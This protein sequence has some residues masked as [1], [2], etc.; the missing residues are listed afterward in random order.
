MK[1]GLFL[2]LILLIANACTN[3]EQY[4]VSG[5]IEGAKDKMLYLERMDLNQTVII[6]SVKIKNGDFEFKQDRLTEPTF[7]MLKL[8][9]KNYITLLADTTETI[10]INADAKNLE[11]S[12]QLRN[13]IGSVYIQMF[14]KRIRKLNKELNTLVAKY[15]ATDNSEM[16][17]ELEKEYD[18]KLQEHKAFVGEFIMENPRSF[19]GYYAL[20]QNLDDNSAVLNVFDK[21]DQVYFSTLATSLNLYFPESERASHLYNYVLGAKAQQQHQKFAEELIASKAAESGYVDIEA[22]NIQGD[23][24]KL[25][26]LQG[27]TIIVN[28]WA[29]WDE[30]SVAANRHLKKMYNKHKNKGLEVYSVSLDKSK[31]LWEST[32]KK[33]GYTWVDVSDLKYTNSFPARLYNI[34]QLPSNYIISPKGEIIGKNLFGNRLTDKLNEIL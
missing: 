26:S 17:K 14:N 1:Q 20:F 33:E 7:L 25:S 2:L 15:Q 18:Q 29:S 30:K 4:T 34:Q 32:I 27:K 6:D 24:I 12:Y 23:T 9:P 16:K 3:K 22:P 21:K 8:S 28:F 31:V 13:S 19:A 10:V 11:T 5:R